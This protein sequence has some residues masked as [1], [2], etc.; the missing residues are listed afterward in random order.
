VIEVLSKSA[1]FPNRWWHWVLVSLA[2]EL[3]W[4][5][6]LYPLVPKSVPAAVLEALLPLLLLG[7]MYLAVRC[8]WWISK[9]SWS[10]WTRR[11]LA[12]AIVVAVG[13]VGIWAVDWVVVQTP[14][15]FG[16]HVIRS[17]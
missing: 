8:L 1:A 17:L 2:A 12:A 6:F 10:L 3:L 5:C 14:A 11:V 4:F 9:R 7:Y 15:E 16:Y 13:A